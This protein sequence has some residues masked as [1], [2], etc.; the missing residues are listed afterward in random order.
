MITINIII[1]NFVEKSVSFIEEI[2]TV[3]KLD[4]LSSC[5]YWYERKKQGL[6]NNNLM[7]HSEI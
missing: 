2:R 1:S 3:E 4:N 5:I 7:P 6:D